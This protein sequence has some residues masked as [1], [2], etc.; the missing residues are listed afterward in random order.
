MKWWRRCLV[1]EYLLLYLLLIPYPTIFS[2]IWAYEGSFILFFARPFMSRKVNSLPAHSSLTY[3]Y[4]LTEK[5]SNWCKKILTCNRVCTEL[6]WH[7][8]NILCQWTIETVCCRTRRLLKTL[9]GCSESVP[10]GESSHQFLTHFAVDAEDAF[11]LARR[12]NE[13]LKIL[14]VSRSVC[15][16]I[17]LLLRN[18]GKIFTVPSNLICFI[19]K[20]LDS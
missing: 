8:L 6:E 15:Q 9:S 13:C 5:G 2:R 18:L 17:N 20:Q 19:N 11:C 3:R 10:F 16:F 14:A 1:K 7:K 12:M 4:L